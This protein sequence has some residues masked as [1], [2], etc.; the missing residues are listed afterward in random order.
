MIRRKIDKHYEAP[1]GAIE[2]QWLR[3]REE[4]VDLDIPDDD[5][6][7]VRLTFFGGAAAAIHLMCRATNPIIDEIAA[8]K[9]SIGRRAKA[10]RK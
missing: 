4:C 3:F 1:I 6:K 7:R 8:F 10:K 9:D 5:L 2:A